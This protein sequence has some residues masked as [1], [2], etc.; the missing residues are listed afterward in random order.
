MSVGVGFSK[1]ILFGEHFVVYGYPGIALGIQKKVKVEVEGWECGV[2]FDDRVFGEK[3]SLADE[4]DYITYRILKPLFNRFNVGN[5]RLTISADALPASGMGYSASLA[6]ACARALS[7]YVGECLSDSEINDLAFLCEKQAHGNPSGIDN[8]CATYGGVI[9]FMRGEGGNTLKPLRLGAP[10]HLVL[11]DTGVKGD[12]R[13]AVSD[14]AEYVG[15]HPAEAEGVFREFEGLV[16][17][18]R[19]A[20]T[21]GDRCALGSLM[22]ENHRLLRRLGVSSR[23]LEEL[24]KV[25]VDAG[26]LG[27]KITGGGLGGLMVCLVEDEVAQEAVACE[28]KAAGY[29]AIKTRATN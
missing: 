5:V 17:A 22:N 27:A 9:W 20:L 18:A 25:A 3:V 23:R 21:A 24:V 6:V 4:P 8:S 26:A 11:G 1:T 16:Y 28:L 19:D 15:A 14:V 2:F 29:G 10:L 7:A 12:T 13:A